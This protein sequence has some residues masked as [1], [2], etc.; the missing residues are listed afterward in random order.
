MARDLHQLENACSRLS[1]RCQKPRSQAVCRKEGWVKSN[2]ERIIFYYVGNCARTQRTFRNSTRL[3]H[4]SKDRTVLY[5]G[6]FE[7]SSQGLDRPYSSTFQ[8]RN[9]LS[10]SFL[11]SLTTPNRYLNAAPYFEQVKGRQ[12]RK[13]RPSERACKP[14]G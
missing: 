8:D 4:A 3:S 9:L 5:F 13:F 2:R 14:K 1:T 6:G 12:C 11:I 10:S 7:P